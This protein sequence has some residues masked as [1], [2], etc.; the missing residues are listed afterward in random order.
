MAVM[1]AAW[2]LAAGAGP[3]TRPAHDDAEYAARVKR[4]R[5]TL[6]AGFTVV[7]E[8]PFVVAGDDTPDNVVTAVK[9]VAWAVEHLKKE[10][11]AND[12]VDLI[13]IYLFKDRASYDKY[14]WDLFREKPDTPYG[15]Y[16]PGRKALVMNIAT[17]GGTLVHEI[18]H[19]FVAANFPRKDGQSLCPPWF[20]EGLGSLYEQSTARND[21]IVGLTNWRLEGLQ[22]AIREKQ[23]PTFKDLCALSP[24]AF[25]GD[26]RGVN[27]AAARY[28]L[29]Y[30]QEKDLLKP[31]YAAF[32]KNFDQDPTGYQTLIGILKERDMP[33]FQERWAAWVMTLKYP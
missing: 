1:L 18:V 29:Y 8:K 31:Y 7:V 17:G 27:Y 26:A 25:Y 23:V 2:A 32:L 13:D 30:L 24:D 4:L 14:T 10:Y 9:T 6:P 22:K 19:P 11:F 15:Y 3:A 33:A 12:P 20:N 5:E 16:S 21:R 28:L